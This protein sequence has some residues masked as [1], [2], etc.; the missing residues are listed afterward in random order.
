MAWGSQGFTDEGTQGS[1][2][3]VTASDCCL[4]L[5]KASR[6][7][8]K[9]EA[10]SR[11][12]D[13]FI[14]SFIVGC[15][16]SSC[17]VWAFCGVQSGGC[18]LLPWLLWS[19]GAGS[20]TWASLPRGTRESSRPGVEPTAPALASG[21]LAAGPP[22]QSSSRTPC[23]TR[24]MSAFLNMKVVFVHFKMEG[25]LEDTDPVTQK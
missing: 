22:G 6:V 11:L 17:W 9:R 3:E 15:T 16:G 25:K 14:R 7:C 12:K 2:R 8:F 20:R 13:V 4:C 18:S 24:L 21:L 19:R 23:Q 5:G 10:V 1:E